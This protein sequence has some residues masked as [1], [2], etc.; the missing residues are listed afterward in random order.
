MD[1]GI[2][3]KHSY[4]YCRKQWRSKESVPAAD[5]IDLLYCDFR[6]LDDLTISAHLE[7]HIH[8]RLIEIRWVDENNASRVEHVAHL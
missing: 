3:N 4:V 5:W 6:K 7:Q 2:N 1:S 8:C